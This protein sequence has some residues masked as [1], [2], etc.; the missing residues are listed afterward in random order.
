MET[1]SSDFRSPEVRSSCSVATAVLKLKGGAMV[2]VAVMQIV[3]ISRGQRWLRSAT[4]NTLTTLPRVT[5]NLARLS[6][7]S[8]KQARKA[9]VLSYHP[10]FGAN[11]F[12]MRLYI[13]GILARTRRLATEATQAKIDYEAKYAEKLKQKAQ[14]EGV[15]SV[16]ALKAR[17]KGSKPPSASL[18]PS[19]SSSSPVTAPIPS[20][21]ATSSTQP[22]ST[23][24]KQ[25]PE[26]STSS[27]P[28]LDKIMKIELL[29]KEDPKTIGDIWTKYHVTKDCISAVIPGET[30]KT[31]IQRSQKYPM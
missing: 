5:L 12:G 30:Y 25:P 20:S 6:A 7:R 11:S 9:E 3:S 23:L 19:T 2:G 29:E 18:R 24:A 21:A 17:I 8:I 14:Q 15:E 27:T 26:I 22:A 28:S 31:I 10:R 1:T 13:R 4:M 16:E